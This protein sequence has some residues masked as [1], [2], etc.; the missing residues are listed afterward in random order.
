MIK[1]I[2]SNFNLPFATAV[3][4]FAILMSDAKTLSEF[5]ATLCGALMGAIIVGFVFN[6][7]Y[8]AR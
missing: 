7:K 8:F 3:F 2:F 5:I 6:K 4:G 1:R